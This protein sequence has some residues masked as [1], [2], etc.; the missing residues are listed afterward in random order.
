MFSFNK[1]THIALFFI[2]IKNMINGGMFDDAHASNGGLS[3]CNVLSSIN[4][5]S[6]LYYILKIYNYCVLLYLMNAFVSLQFVY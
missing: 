4:F 3:G 2:C 1:W 6:E 5:V